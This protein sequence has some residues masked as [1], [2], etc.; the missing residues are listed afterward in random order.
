[1]I[2]IAIVNLYL[3]C[4]QAIPAFN[5]SAWTSAGSYELSL[6]LEDVLMP[7][8]NSGFTIEF[9]LYKKWSS[10]VT[11][12]LLKAASAVLI[13]QVGGPSTDPTSELTFEGLESVQLENLGWHHIAMTR[14]P[15]ALTTS[16]YANAT[17]QM[18][19]EG[20]DVDFSA[21]IL[22]DS[23]VNVK[24]L[25][26]ELRIWRTCRSQAQIEAL[27]Y[28]VMASYSDGLAVLYH[29]SESSGRIIYDT[30][31]ILEVHLP[32]DQVWYDVPFIV[33]CQ[34]NQIYMAGGC[35]ACPGAC[36]ECDATGCLRCLPG[37]TTLPIDFDGTGTVKCEHSRNYFQSAVQW[38]VI[39]ATLDSSQFTNNAYT[40]EMWLYVTSSNG[41]RVFSDCAT[42]LIMQRGYF[43]LANNST[44][45][46]YKEFYHKWYHL[47]LNFATDS[48]VIY[49]NGVLTATG[50]EPWV[51]EPTCIKT[52]RVALAEVKMY[53]YMK[54]DGSSQTYAS[55]I[56]SELGSATL[57]TYYWPL[58]ETESTFQ[59][60]GSYG[61]DYAVHIGSPISLSVSPSVCYG[62]QTLFETGFG[63][64]SICID[65][66]AS[67]ALSLSA[68]ALTLTVSYPSCADLETAASAIE[69]WYK[70]DTDSIADDT[71][72]ADFGELKFKKASGHFKY[73]L[74]SA[75]LSA[76]GPYSAN[77]WKHNY[78]SFQKAVVL[79]SL[80]YTES[81][82][83]LELAL[84]S[85]DLDPCP[86][87]FE[88]SVQPGAFVRFVRWWERE[89]QS[90]AVLCSGALP[91][92]SFVGL[93]LSIL[94][95]DYPLNEAD[96]SVVVDASINGKT[97]AVDST[98]NWAPQDTS[99]FIQKRRL[100]Y[101]CKNSSC[102]ESSD[103]LGGVLA[104]ASAYFL[105]SVASSQPT[106]S[107][108]CENRSSTRYIQMLSVFS[109]PISFQGH[110]TSLVD[111]QL[112]TSFELE[113]GFLTNSRSCDLINIG[114]NAIVVST[115]I[116]YGALYLSV[117]GTLV[118]IKERW[119]YSL[120]YVNYQAL[121]VARLYL[122]GVELTTP[123]S[124][125]T[126]PGGE[127]AKAGYGCD[128]LISDFKIVNSLQP[129]HERR[130][131][132]W[133]QTYADT[134]SYA[135]NYN[136]TVV[137]D[138]FVP[139]QS[140]VSNSANSDSTNSAR[141]DV[142][143][144]SQKFVLKEALE[145]S[146]T[147][148]ET[149]RYTTCAAGQYRKYA[150]GSYSCVDC[151]TSNCKACSKTQCGVC[152]ANYYLSLTSNTEATCE[153]TCPSS[154]TTAETP[155]Q[156]CKRTDCVFPCTYCYGNKKDECL[157][158]SQKLSTYDYYGFLAS[159]Y[160][161]NVYYA[162]GSSISL[163]QA[164]PY[165]I[166]ALFTSYFGYVN[167]SATDP[168]SALLIN[169]LEV[170]VLKDK[171]FLYNGSSL[172][173]SCEPGANLKGVLLSISATASAFQGFIADPSSDTITQCTANSAYVPQT[174]SSIWIGSDPN[175]RLAD[176]FI[177]SLRVLDQ[178]V[179]INTNP[180]NSFFLSITYRPT[181]SAVVKEY[182]LNEGPGGNSVRDS[183]A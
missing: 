69:F 129:L 23:Q 17:L 13:E 112:W 116:Q 83:A 114:G 52:Y 88:F 99:A 134:M 119:W 95:M 1:M 14:A 22:G 38:S 86:T 41:D 147:L 3:A 141:N 173:L 182:P 68:Q 39:E 183:K 9:W 151:S 37:Y 162:T 118:P 170:K 179:T 85:S 29:L 5:P 82:C 91:F 7:D 124:K 154:T 148:R 70:A 32:T 111:Q 71:V 140:S 178:A 101:V 19:Y 169:S 90:S 64:E 54:N 135:P 49:V 142:I 161:F 136:Y 18:T 4:V 6:N 149:S 110:T 113:I 117:Q 25:W 174:L 121:K 137:Y 20:V 153:L 75:E 102:D 125:I 166:Q 15:S 106:S 55:Y 67:T 11:G 47:S 43:Q 78:V 10:E 152:T 146:P 115:A 103:N 165:T 97:T 96:I 127:I 107:T 36:V 143:D 104:S 157:A 167:L 34:N 92:T 171:L 168:T 138:T 63:S 72:L 94:R 53:N 181:S 81:P 123:N 73:S 33:I 100:G 155:Q 132:F 172:L 87:K 31:N 60:R 26:R 79:R 80:D 159:V 50:S 45:T 105:C 126:F 144:L 74:G 59:A 2:F 46:V 98:Q 66:A 24:S 164:V 16:V 51:V 30:E 57:P 35:T 44:L 61:S 133:D 158:Y 42:D 27:H 150:A 131:V 76:G 8:T 12:T 156:F 65:A 89:I 160:P 93:N 28:N 58:L 77:T 56:S 176:N 177:A 180:L 145:Y 120:R 21:A 109:N 139:S 122:N 84:T 48:Q 175:I 62:S 40:A 163:S 130:S 128:C 108:S